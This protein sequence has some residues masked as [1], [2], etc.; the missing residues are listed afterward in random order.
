MVTVL[1]YVFYNAENL[2]NFSSDFIIISTFK[3][4]QFLFN[5]LILVNTHH[6]YLIAINFGRDNN[7]KNY[8]WKR[9]TFLLNCYEQNGRVDVNFAWFLPTPRVHEHTY[10]Y[11][12]LY[13]FDNFTHNIGQYNFDRYTGRNTFSKVS[14]LNL[15]LFHHI[16]WEKNILMNFLFTKWV[17]CMPAVYYDHSSYGSDDTYKWKR[18]INYRIVHCM[19][20]KVIGRRFLVLFR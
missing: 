19:V 14:I 11:Q 1:G 2:S 4:S 16:K 6:G 9:W 17:V 7:Y 18:R 15:N 8:N 12:S 13:M 5:G 20:Y 3:T 10:T